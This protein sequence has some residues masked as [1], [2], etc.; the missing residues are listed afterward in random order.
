[1]KKRLRLTNLSRFFAIRLIMSRFFDSATHKGYQPKNQFYNLI[2]L[3]I[4][5]SI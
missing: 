5:I 4:T 3:L 2:V 1:M